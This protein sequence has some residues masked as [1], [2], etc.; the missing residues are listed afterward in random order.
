MKK[1]KGY[2]RM[3][4]PCNYGRKGEHVPNSGNGHPKSYYMHLMSFDKY[5]YLCLYPLQHLELSVFLI[6]FIQMSR[7]WCFFVGLTCIS[8]MNNNDEHFL[9]VYCSSY[10][11]SGEVSFHIFSPS[12]IGLSSYLV[13]RI[14]YISDINLLSDICFVNNFSHCVISRFMIL[15][16]VS[17]SFKEQNFLVMIKSN[18]S[19][20]YGSCVLH[21]I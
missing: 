2:Y 19:I 9:W 6:L 8:L 17:L 10:I 4:L 13:V 21:P 3:T 11:F 18:L 5:I 7:Q 12:F 16:T 15:S 14:I 20:F 1:R